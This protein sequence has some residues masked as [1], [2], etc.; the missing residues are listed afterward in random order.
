MPK[1]NNGVYTPPAGNPVVTD[2][3][4]TTDWAN[5]TLDYIYVA[6]NDNLSRSGGNGMGVTLRAVDG[7]SAEPAYNF[8]PDTT[9][10][11]FWLDGEDVDVVGSG[12]PLRLNGAKPAEFDVLRRLPAPQ[13]FLEAGDFGGNPNPEYFLAATL[14]NG[15]WHRVSVRASMNTNAS[16][17]SEL[18]FADKM[19]LRMYL[20]AM[21]SIPSDLEMFVIGGTPSSSVGAETTGQRTV[22]IEEYKGNAVM[23]KTYAMVASNAFL[24]LENT[25]LDVPWFPVIELEAFVRA[26]SLVEPLDFKLS[27]AAAN[28]NDVDANSPDRDRNT[29]FMM[30]AGSRFDEI[31]ALNYPDQGFD[32]AYAVPM[33]EE[34]EL[35][36]IT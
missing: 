29:L 12:I 21:D 31:Y 36:V 11:G 8:A 22:R 15:G 28:Y 13:G 23:A 4:I 20:T 24:P 5:P 16:G 17:I 25:A 6:I 10:S 26:P 35:N 3:V 19:L 32:P 14:Q 9:G 30:G 2:T 27:F 34:I 7:S 33:V 1:N 18:A